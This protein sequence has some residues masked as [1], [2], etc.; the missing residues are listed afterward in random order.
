MCVPT[1]RDLC[2][3]PRGLWS[4]YNRC[5]I[6]PRTS[7]SPSS[8]HRSQ[9][10]GPRQQERPPPCGQQQLSDLCPAATQAASQSPT[11][12]KSVHCYDAIS[13]RSHSPSS[14]VPQWCQSCPRPLHCPLMSGRSQ[15]PV[16]LPM[17]SN[18]CE[19]CPMHPLSA[20]HCCL[21][22]GSLL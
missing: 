6:C 20:S 8:A 11:G 18:G 4:L 21:V 5:Q 10:V 15:V 19:I 7:Q 22:P 2:Q 17:V 14:L 13:P 9:Q 1:S 12:V 16:S 3:E